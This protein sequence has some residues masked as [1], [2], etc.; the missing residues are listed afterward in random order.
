MS[1][2]LN[3]ESST[4]N[5]NTNA[6]LN[7]ISIQSL[8][9]EMPLNTLGEYYD[10]ETSIFKKRIDKLNLKFYWESEVLAS[11]KDI[12]KPYNKL[13][14]ILFKQINLF[15]E[16][17]ERLN[18]IIK[19]KNKNEKYFKE[20]IYEFTQKEKDRI[21]TKQMLK[22]VQK[23][24]K[25]LEKR[26][27]EKALY[28][29]KLKIELEKMKHQL[30]H[31]KESGMNVNN[32]MPSINVNVNQT[33]KINSSSNHNVKHLH[34]NSSVSNNRTSRSI[35][36]HSNVNNNA[37]TSTSTST[38]RPK[39]KKRN[40]NNYNYN[41]QIMLTQNNNKTFNNLQTEINNSNANIIQDN[42][43]NNNDM[44][45]DINLIDQCMSHYLDEI[46]HLEHIEMFL[47]KQR[48]D[49]KDALTKQNNI[50]IKNKL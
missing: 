34:Y 44:I 10:I 27:K 14:L 11:Q 49:I 6:S 30:Q 37:R 12:P 1:T 22:N 33:Q 50:L 42:N 26:I 39:I 29:D 18:N 45:N 28:E 32:S 48:K 24:N 3:D 46:E 41:N 25:L 20:K 40:I 43:I 35:E 19:D 9:N 23:T 15:T 16:E 2:S 17:V 7:N 38:Q 47:E 13:F 36:F 5:T 4:Q 21:L 31:I 8:L